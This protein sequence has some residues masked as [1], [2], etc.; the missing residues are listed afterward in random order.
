MRGSKSERVFLTSILPFATD[1]TL[2][3]VNA[4]GQAQDWRGR[5][6]Q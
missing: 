5:A 2:W 1:I 3:I 6:D 4:K